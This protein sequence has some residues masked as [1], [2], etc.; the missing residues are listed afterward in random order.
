MT[1]FWRIGIKNKFTEAY[2]SYPDA[3]LAGKVLNGCV[4]SM[5][6]AHGDHIGFLLLL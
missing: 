4:K 6:Q 2:F 3:R 5:E 1:E